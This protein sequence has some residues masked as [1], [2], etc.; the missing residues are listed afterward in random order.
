MSYPDLAQIDRAA[1]EI[2]AARKAY[3]EAAELLAGQIATGANERHA[4][5]LNHSELPPKSWRVGQSVF[6]CS[7]SA[8]STTNASPAPAITPAAHGVVA[9]ELVRCLAQLGEHRRTANAECS[10]A[11]SPAR[12]QVVF[13]AAPGGSFL[14]Y[15]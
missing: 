12:A 14:P 15:R 13:L 5:A 11:G 9:A 6:A 3:R 8:E 10:L 2:A 4:V 7:K 1:T